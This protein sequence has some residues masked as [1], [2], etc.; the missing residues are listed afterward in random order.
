MLTRTLF[1]TVAVLAA[2]GLPL[3]AANDSHA[4][5]QKYYHGTECVMRGTTNPQIRYGRGGAINDATTAKDFVCPVVR[6]VTGSDV[7]DWDVWVDRNGYTGAWTVQLYSCDRTGENCYSWTRTVPS[8]TDPID[9]DGGPVSSYLDRGYMYILSSVPP[10][11]LIHGYH[12][13]ESAGT[14]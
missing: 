8:G 3:I 6:D 4:A 5:D 12:V 11:A 10:G 1:R 2:F 14:E 9:A 7:T 13:N